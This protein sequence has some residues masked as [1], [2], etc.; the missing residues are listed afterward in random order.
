[1]NRT[2][3]LL[4]F[5]KIKELWTTFAMT[6]AVKEK[7]LSAVPCLDEK[8]LLLWQKE[9]SE[10][11]KMIETYGNPPLISFLALP[12][13]LKCAEK[14]GC[15][16]PQDLEFVGTT[17][18]SVGR[19][20]SYLGR[21]KMNDFSLAYY[22]ENLN[23]CDALKEQIELQIRNGR[24]DD[25]ATKHLSSIRSELE[26]LKDK[27]HAR[28]DQIMRANKDAMA[29]NF[30][31]TRNGRIALPV[32][33]DCKNKINGTL[34]DKSSSGSTVFI[35]PAS[36]GKYY[37]DIQLLKM[38]EENEEMRIR[39]ELT[40]PILDELPTLTENMRIIEKLDFAFSKGKLS[41]EMDGAQPQINTNRQIKLTD[42]RHP[43]MDRSCCVPLQF[44][45]QDAV[46]GIIITGPNTGGK[47]VTL[48]T[49]ALNCMMAQCGLH[50]PC[51]SADICMNS[52]YLC[53]IGDGQNLSKN[54]STFSAHLKNILSILNQV[55]AESLVILDELGSGTDPTEGM[56]IAIAVLEQLKKSGALF[57][58]T[59]HYPEIK[60]YAKN[61]TSIINARMDFDKENLKPLYKLIIGEAG[62]SCAFSI[63]KRLGMSEE[64]LRIAAI[65]SYG[66]TASGDTA[67][68]DTTCKDNSGQVDGGFGSAA[69]DLKP[70]TFR[71]DTFKPDNFKP[72][73]PK[74]RKVKPA[75]TNTVSNAAYRFHLGDSVMVLPDKKIGIVCKTA[76]EKGV[77]QVQMPDKKIWINHK[78]IKLHVASSE[79]Y[80]EDYDFSIIFD[81]V[82]NRKLRHQMDRKYI[83]TPILSKKEIKQQ[84]VIT[85][86]L[87]LFV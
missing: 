79:L 14:E 43:L 24:V 49:V 48:K 62:E 1:M 11:K 77:P 70:N 44:H 73:A 31:T 46:R 84:F 41:L 45:M 32:K 87:S 38:N 5:D 18:T 9:T 72:S 13:I 86:I 50:V 19:L 69:H 78:R 57:L 66:N 59:T 56:G 65:A 33:K 61:E 71:Q 16:S 15:L 47:T 21:C 23:A 53:D 34:L 10:A 27:M 29:D 81:T 63:A 75:S 2:E 68:R 60:Q 6:D 64:M 20:K 52:N 74:I 80:P 22:D 28:A 83:L 54:L 25:Y 51:S 4:E 30:S 82:E 36:V 12:S 35:E 67:Y 39:Y 58:V 8:M 76:N 37:E 7:I 42:A 85:V 3:Q 55:N 17:L 40:A 26:T